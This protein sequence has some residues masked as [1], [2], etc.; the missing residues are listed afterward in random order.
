LIIACSN[1]LDRLLC[2]LWSSLVLSD[3]DGLL[4]ELGDGVLQRRV[5]DPN[6]A[7]ERAVQLFTVPGDGGIDFGAVLIALKAAD[8]RGWLVV[9]AEQD[10]AKTPPLVY[11][12]RGFV[13]LSAAVRETGW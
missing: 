7:F 3:A 13:H 9:E 8:Y 2:A 11:A 12:R 6:N 4:A 5:G 1:N 10:P